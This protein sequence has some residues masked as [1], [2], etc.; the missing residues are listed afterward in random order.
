LAPFYCDATPFEAGCPK[1]RS[2]LGGGLV[3]TFGDALANFQQMYYG[4]LIKPWGIIIVVLLALVL[5]SIVRWL[6]TAIYDPTG[7][8]IKGATVAAYF[9]LLLAPAD[10]AGFSK[11]MA[12]GFV[13]VPIAIAALYGIGKEINLFRVSLLNKR[14]G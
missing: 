13:S 11:L 4:F 10:V 6:W 14:A 8:G 3:D 1:R 2:A 12:T 7:D 5:G 9:A